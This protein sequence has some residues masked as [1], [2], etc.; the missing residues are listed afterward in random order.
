MYQQG[1][2][3]T[4]EV[5]GQGRYHGEVRGEIEG[6]VIGEHKGRVWI[7]SDRYDTTRNPTVKSFGIN[8]GKLGG[9]GH[10]RIKEIKER[11][12]PCDPH[13]YVHNLRA[14]FIDVKRNNVT[15]TD[16]FGKK[17]YEMTEELLDIII[18]DLMKLREGEYEN[19]KS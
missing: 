8:S 15:R 17:I 1:D 5:L 9:A 11:A 12:Y 2:K 3:V 13:N 16:E 6:V 7:Y 19:R 18:R 14:A 10:Y 4:L